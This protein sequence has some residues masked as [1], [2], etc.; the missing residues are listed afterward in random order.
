MFD[1]LGF[2]AKQA[3][4]FSQHV[5]KAWS[6]VARGLGKVSA[7][8]DRLAI[9]VEKH[10]Q[11]PPAVFAK[12]VQGRHVDLVDVGPL[13]AVDFDVDEQLVHD[14]SYPFVFEAFMRHGMAPVARCVADR[15][16]D[17]LIS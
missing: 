15:Y 2:V 8:P 7:A 6:T 16:K 3:S 4:D 1:A 12:M 17:R 5:H 10:G 13:L 11:R 14:G 9:A